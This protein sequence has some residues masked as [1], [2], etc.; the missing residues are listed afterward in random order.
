MKNI[1]LTLS[2]LLVS[3]FAQCSVVIMG[4]RVIYPEGSRSINVNLSNGD[5]SPA[6]I[7]AWFDDGNV[8]KEPDVS[9]IP[10]IITPPVFRIAPH[11]GQTMRIMYT[12]EPLPNDKESLFWLNV[13]DIPAKPDMISNTGHTSLNNYLQFAV[14]SRINF[15][16]RPSNLVISTNDAYQKVQWNLSNGNKLTASNPTPYYITFN[17]V[18]YERDGKKYKTLDGGMIAPFSSEQFNLDNKVSA[19]GKVLWRVIDDNGGFQHG[20]SLIQ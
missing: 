1:L 17:S 11:T 7:Q 16:Y 9:K 3:F 5:S 14:R 20:E 18:M 2:L 4:T 10:F 13:M 12:G 15:F 19:P 6:L 8:S